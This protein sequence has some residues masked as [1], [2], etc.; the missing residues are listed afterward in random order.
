MDILNEEIKRDFTFFD[1]K[2]NDFI[3]K[4]R[5][6]IHLKNMASANY[7]IRQK[8]KIKEIKVQIEAEED[9]R[10]EIELSKYLYLF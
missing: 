4:K 2:K 5:V 10:N 8:E 6:E 3:E 7:E 1:L 9:L